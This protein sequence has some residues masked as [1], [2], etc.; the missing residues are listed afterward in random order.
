MAKPKRGL[1]KFT[2]Y[3]KTKTVAVNGFKYLVPSDH[4]SLKVQQHFLTCPA[5]PQAQYGIKPI[6]FA[7]YSYYCN[8]TKQI[9]YKYHTEL[10]SGN[11][12]NKSKHDKKQ[13]KKMRKQAIRHAQHAS[14]LARLEAKAAI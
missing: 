7:S 6:Q 3:P 4:G 9:V 10:A 11:V 8:V 14:T 13:A 12:I 2:R 1:L 5:R